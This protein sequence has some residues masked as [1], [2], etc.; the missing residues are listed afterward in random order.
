M[1]NNFNEIDDLFKSR[2]EGLKD[3]SVSPSSQW[4]NFEAQ[5]NKSMAQTSTRSGGK[6]MKHL[7]MA[8]SVA[9]VIGISL[10]AQSDI[11][12][13]YNSD[14]STID[15]QKEVIVNAESWTN[16]ETSPFVNSASFGNVFDLSINASNSEAFD[17]AFSAENRE[18]NSSNIAIVNLLENELIAEEVS[19][20][21]SISSHIDRPSISETNNSIENSV[22]RNDLAFMPAVKQNDQA[23]QLSN[24]DRSI[25]ISDYFNKSG[26][27]SDLFLRLGV[28][29]GTGE[30]NSS[31]NPNA[32]TANA[33]AGIG[34]KRAINS[35][36]GW[37]AE[38]AYLRRSG[39]GLERHQ[40]LEIE[41]SFSAYNTSF[42]A[43]GNN[44][45]EV[46]PDFTVDRSLVADRLDYIQLPVSVYYNT[47]QKTALN[48]GVYGE[49]LFNAQNKAYVIYN[50]VNY[51]SLNTSDEEKGSV[52]GLNRIRY[53]VTAGA[54]YE[55]MQNLH[56]DIRALI[57]INAT[58]NDNAAMC[59]SK[60][61]N[62]SL[63]LLI[64][65]KYNI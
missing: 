29:F 9:G 40:N 22:L 11:S 20:S 49:F 63:D 30:S 17:E 32:W 44:P 19:N 43:G 55:I 51:V 34:F 46:V 42:N 37:M 53:G 14:Y 24:T 12:Q 41:R 45:L 15:Q 62:K 27:A 31:Q 28:R 65:L 4:S 6:A 10:L 47:T 64:S 39:N 33:L 5:M 36:Y 1:D 21:S 25:E 60:K 8:A 13:T 52:E 54:S 57:P 3:H 58:F 35:K 56:L 16:N 61:A 59:A 23:A 48:A 50:N 7:S 2:F 18:Y 26:I 38:L